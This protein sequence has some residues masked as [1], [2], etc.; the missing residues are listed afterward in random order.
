M[1]QATEIYTKEFETLFQRLP[2]HVRTRILAKIRELGRRL[3]D[4]SHERLQGRGEFKLRVGDYRVI[5]EFD[6]SLNEI[7]LITVGHR[8]EVYR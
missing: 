6:A 8:R 7:Y 2:P 5:Y 4:F 3:T 1:G